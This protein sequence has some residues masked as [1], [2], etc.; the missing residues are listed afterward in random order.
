MGGDEKRQ[1]LGGELMNPFPKIASRFWID[2]RCRL[3]QQEQLRAMNETSGK[4]EALFPS[5]RELAGEFVFAFRQPELLDAFTNG[6]SPIL[7]VIHARD[8]IEI[9]FN[10]QI[11]PKTESLRHVTDFPLNCLAFGNHVVTQN[12]TASV[13]TSEQAAKHAQKG[14]LAAAVW[15]EKSVDLARRHR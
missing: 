14:S 10:A 11:F 8:K 7:H 13:V 12:P 15:A 1:R 6:L 5:T 3:V 2:A 4:R 9:F